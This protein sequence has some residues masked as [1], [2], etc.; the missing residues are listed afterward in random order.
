M[1]RFPTPSVPGR[2]RVP[3]HSSGTWI[4][5]SA[6]K[7]AWAWGWTLSAP[8]F[9]ALNMENLSRIACTSQN[10][11]PTCC[12][13]TETTFHFIYFISLS[14]FIQTSHFAIFMDTVAVIAYVMLN[15]WSK[16]RFRL[17]TVIH[18]PEILVGLILWLIRMQCVHIPFQYEHC[19]WAAG[20]NT[21]W[22]Y[23]FDMNRSK[24]KHTPTS[25]TRISIP[26]LY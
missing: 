6:G 23:T 2:H 8:S 19:F 16:L 17:E 11:F 9:Q 26:V 15:E 4:S 10:T 1:W 24:C 21:I 25:Y 3:T 18:R 22:L 12:F 13:R 7:S 5:F 14:C 20:M